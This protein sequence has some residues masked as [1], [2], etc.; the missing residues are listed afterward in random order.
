MRFMC[1]F[2]LASAVICCCRVRS[3]RPGFEA[4][5]SEDLRLRL[6]GKGVPRL[7]MEAEHLLLGHAAL[8]GALCAVEVDPETALDVP[9]DPLAQPAVDEPFAHLVANDLVS[10]LRQVLENGLLG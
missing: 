8:M 6:F 5:Y 4:R 3:L 9:F 1:V 7:D 2:V 10:E